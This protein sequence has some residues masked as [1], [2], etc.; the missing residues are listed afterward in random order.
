M[1]DE[2]QSLVDRSKELVQ[3]MA[4]ATEDAIIETVQ[5]LEQQEQKEGK[6]KTRI[7]NPMQAE[8]DGVDPTDS[9]EME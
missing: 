8:D 1:Y 5:M 6:A 4:K 9:T 2:V 3:E 7:V